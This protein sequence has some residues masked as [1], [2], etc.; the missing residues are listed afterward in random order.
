ME[1]NNN[2]ERD[3]FFSEK[4]GKILA[5]IGLLTIFIGTTIYLIFGSWSFSSILNEEIIGQFGEFIGGVVGSILAMSG[6]ILYYVALKEQRKEIGVSQDALKC[7]VEALNQQI[8]EFREQK[9]EMQE[10]RKLYDEQTK[11]FRRQTKISK[12]QQFASSFYSLLDVFINVREELNKEKNYFSSIYEEL[13]IIDNNQQSSIINIFKAI[14]KKYI[15]LY[16]DHYLELNHYFKTFYRM[17]KLIEESGIEKS[18]KLVYFK[19]FRSQITS[20]ELLLFF[21]NC[22]SELAKKVRSFVIKYDLLKDLSLLDRIEFNF[23]GSN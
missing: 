5:I 2:S 13:R 19:I 22:H 11:E 15:E 16:Y 4:T 6:I 17:V 14:N 10:T 8:V 18:D 9:K 20:K 21:Y 7:Q 3:S 23:K 1:S 12:H